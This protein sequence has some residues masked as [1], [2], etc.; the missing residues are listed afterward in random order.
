VR[1]RTLGCKVNRV[2]SDT[3]AERLLGSGWEVVDEGPA[4]VVVVNTCTVTAEADS[5]A[6]KEIRRA[7]ASPGEPLVL[8]T[9]CL[10]ALHAGELSAMSPRVVV[11]TDRD[12]VS[13][14]VQA[15]G[16]PADGTSRGAGPADRTAGPAV[17]RTRALLKVQDGCS[18]R[19]SYCI[20]PDARGLPRSRPL[21]EILAE[22]AR[23][24]S[25]GVREIVVTGVNVGA[26]RD[27]RAELPHLLDALCSAASGRIRLSSV[28]PTHLT[29]R[30]AEVAA[31]RTAEG[32]L[33]PHFHVPLQSGCDRVLSA[34]RRPYDAERYAAAVAM[35]RAAVPG[36]ALT[37]DVI[38]GFPGES[39]AEASETLAFVEGQTFQR[40]HVFRYSEREG[41]PATAIMPR[42]AAA[43]R[44]ARAAALRDLS[45]RLL[46]GYTAD[47]VGGRARVLVETAG[48]GTTEDY[49]RVAVAGEMAPGSLVGVTLGRSATAESLIGRVSG[50]EEH[51]IVHGEDRP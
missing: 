37:T 38:A 16:R 50:D 48:T 44:S 13:R 23:L 43:E 36:V 41:A 20:V 24:E 39:R 35:L 42:V 7:L 5:K 19:C 26:W 1:F 46:A 32:T 17:P 28:E 51:R 45:D 11:E 31:R 40:L 25:A 30:F 27:D 4:D 8:V 33:C 18:Q 6:R 47:R 49:L 12:G 34:M 10:A 21:S 9:G 2:E 3:A 14:A 15:L 29:D 22:V